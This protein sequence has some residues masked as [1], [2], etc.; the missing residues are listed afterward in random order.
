MII[1]FIPDIDE[2][3]SDELNE[4]HPLADCSNAVGSYICTCQEGFTSL[5]N[6]AGRTC[7]GMRKHLSVQIFTSVGLDSQVE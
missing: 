7:N 5:G 2:C 6:P 4:C 3:L 1:F